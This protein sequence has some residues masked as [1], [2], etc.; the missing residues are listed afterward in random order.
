LI[1]LVGTTTLF[2]TNSPHTIRGNNNNT[3]NTKIKCENSKCGK[4]P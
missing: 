3:I 1:S 2:T 4:K